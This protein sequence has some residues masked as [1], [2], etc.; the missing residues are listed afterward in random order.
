MRKLK[1]ICIFEKNDLC[2]S[3][4]AIYQIKRIDIYFFSDDTERNFDNA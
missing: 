2:V 1:Y 3:T 4:E